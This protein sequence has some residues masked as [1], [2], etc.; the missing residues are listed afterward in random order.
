LFRHN[1]AVKDPD[2]AEKATIILTG[3]TRGLGLAMAQGLA[4]EPGIS[5]ILAVRDLRAGEDVA[6]NLGP[7]VRVLEL[8]MESPT[9]IAAFARSMTGPIRALVNNAGGQ[10]HGAAQ[11]TPDGIERTLALNHLGPLR[12]ITALSDRLGGGTVLTIGS[13]THNPEDRLARMFGFRGG[14]FSSIE[15]LARGKRMRSHFAWLRWSAT[16]RASF[17]SWQAPWNWRAGCPR[18][19]S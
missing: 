13:G 18:P 2:M 14:R 17:W 1:H 6:R 7:A 4:R 10:F 5:L 9:S 3:A 19:A 8:D 12:L 15:A 16:P 11:F